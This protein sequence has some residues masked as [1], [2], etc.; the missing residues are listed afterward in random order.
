[1]IERIDRYNIRVDGWRIPAS[2]SQ[3][4][5]IRALTSEQRQNFLRIMGKTR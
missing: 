2:E 1:M 3:E 5:R 4:A